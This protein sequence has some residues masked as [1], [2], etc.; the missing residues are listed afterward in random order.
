[1]PDPSY[2]YARF[3][4][5]FGRERPGSLAGRLLLRTTW[6]I[7]E[8][9][10][11]FREGR[12]AWYAAVNEFAD[13]TPDEMAALRGYRRGL[14][15]RVRASSVPAADGIG[16]VRGPPASVDWRSSDNASKVSV[17]LRCMLG[18]LGCRVR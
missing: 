15:E 12:S 2:S 13:W 7:L 8:Q 9:N 14:A 4:A 11:A 5:D 10:R 3:V 18:L 16:E 6:G 1:M 17:R